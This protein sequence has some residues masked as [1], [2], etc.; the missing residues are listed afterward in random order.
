MKC[1]AIQRAIVAAKHAH[2]TTNHAIDW[3]VRGP[4]STLNFAAYAK[5]ANA[6]S[7]AA[8]RCREEKIAIAPHPLRTA[9]KNNAIQLAA[10]DDQSGGKL[11]METTIV[12]ILAKMAKIDATRARIEF[13]FGTL[14]LDRT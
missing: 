13:S 3:C 7:I 12:A 6:L 11:G 1:A 14:I 2:P 8:R 5:S 10:L 4:D 9:G